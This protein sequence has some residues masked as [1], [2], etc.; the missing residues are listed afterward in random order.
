VHIEDDGHITTASGADTASWEGLRLFHLAVDD[1]HQVLNV[2]RGAHGAEPDEGSTPEH[3]PE[4]PPVEVPPPEAE[5]PGEE[6]AQIRVLG[7][8]AIVV[9]GKELTTGLRGKARELLT[10]LALNSDGVTRDAALEALWPDA[11]HKQAVQNFH[12]AVQ[13]VRRALRR[14]T[15]RANEDFITIATDR[16]RIDARLVAVDLWR[17]R[18]ALHQASNAS[19]D[20]TRVALLQEAVDAY[21]GPLAA[22]Q[23]Y[24]WVEPEREA[25]RRQAV[26]ALVHLAGL[27]EREEPERAIAALERAKNIDRYAEEIY[28]RT[29]ILQARLGR[30]DAVR[31]THRLLETN[32]EELSADPSE[33]TKKLLWRLL[34]PRGQQEKPPL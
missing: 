31:R 11:P 30:P 3:A 21:Q 4:E 29:M 7:S 8:P 13:D 19:G 27:V 9:D 32:L 5:A 17:F 10:Y 28:Q 34:H 20:N 33:E 24:D 1:A 6:R 2:I 22:E 25:L 23:G 16:Y 15:G 12:A 18:R 14:A 26:D